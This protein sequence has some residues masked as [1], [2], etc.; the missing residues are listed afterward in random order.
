LVALEGVKVAVK[1][2]LPVAMLPIL[3]V[4]MAVPELTVTLEQSASESVESTK[5]TVPAAAD[6]VTVAV[7]VMLAPT[8]AVLLEDDTVVVVAVGVD[9]LLEMLLEPQPAAKIVT[10]V[11]NPAAV[12]Q[13][14][15]RRTFISYLIM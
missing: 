6:G 11:S 9:E 10:T 2:W 5:A 14:S 12:T 4:Q 8:I 13:G 1:V 3:N 15:G 7:S